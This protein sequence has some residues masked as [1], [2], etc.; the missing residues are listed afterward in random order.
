MGLDVLFRLL[1]KPILN[2]FNTLQYVWFAAYMLERNV[3]MDYRILCLRSSRHFL[4]VISS[5]VKYVNVRTI[6]S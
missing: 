1:L 2:L 3:W 5:A 6:F 4:D